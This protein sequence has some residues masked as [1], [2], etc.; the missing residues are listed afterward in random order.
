MML[1][2]CEV[3]R[4]HKYV[5]FLDQKRGEVADTHGGELCRRPVALL[6]LNNLTYSSLNK[7]YQ[8]N[9]RT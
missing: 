1:G 7:H 3:S 8:K 9:W 4:F 6:L 2:D 5:A